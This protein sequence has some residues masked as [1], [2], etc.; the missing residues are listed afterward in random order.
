MTPLL[1]SQEPLIHVLQ[2][3]LASFAYDYVARQKIAGVNFTFNYFT[4]M[5]VPEPRCLFAALAG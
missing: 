5:A 2:A 4:Q 1:F 3:V